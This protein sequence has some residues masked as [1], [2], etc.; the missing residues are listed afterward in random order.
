MAPC[1][2]RQLFHPGREITESDRRPAPVAYAPSAVPNERF[3][4]MPRAMSKAMIGEIVA[5]Y[6]D[7]ARRMRS[8][9]I[10]RRARSWPATAICRRSSSIRASTCATDDYGGAPENRLRFLHEVVADIRAKTDADFVVGLR[11]SGDEKDEQGRSRPA[12][13]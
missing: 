9:G 3:H 4:V 13:R 10:R 5:G 12:R 2:S 11:I 1:S 6:G 7:A 8:A